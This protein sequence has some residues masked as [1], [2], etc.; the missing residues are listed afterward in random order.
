ML[1]YTHK[2]YRLNYQ[3]SRFKRMPG[4]EPGILLCLL[5]LLNIL[6]GYLKAL[7]PLLKLEQI[8]CLEENTLSCLIVLCI[9]NV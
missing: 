2:I 1:N 5:L 7:V 9:S 4:P 8:T 6:H 3:P